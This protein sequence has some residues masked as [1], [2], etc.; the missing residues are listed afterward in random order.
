MIIFSTCVQALVPHKTDFPTLVPGPVETYPKTIQTENFWQILGHGSPRA[1]T[2]VGLILSP[3]SITQGKRYGVS[4]ITVFYKQK[5]VAAA[6]KHCGAY[7]HGLLV[8]NPWKKVLNLFFAFCTIVA[9]VFDKNVS[10]THINV[11]GKI[12]R[13]VLPKWGQLFF[14]VN[15][16]GLRFSEKS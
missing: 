2:N 8:L 6:T 14:T 12:V 4:E 11:D 13:W 9:M 16:L 1:L 10:K 3:T 15:N 5:T 7:H